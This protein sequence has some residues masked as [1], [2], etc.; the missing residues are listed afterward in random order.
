LISIYLVDLTL[1]VSMI[2]LN[3][4]ELIKIFW[5]E[6][7]KSTPSV[8]RIHQ[9]LES[10]GEVVMNDHIAFRT[11]NHPSINID[12]TEKVFLKCGYVQKDT[13]DFE[14]KKLV[15]RHYEHPDPMAPKVFISE[16][17]LEEFSQELRKKVLYCISKIPQGLLQTGM[18]IFSGRTW[19]TI[20]YE[21]YKALLEESEYA[22][23]LYV[24]GFCAN[25]F[26]V[27]V[28]K[29]QTFDSLEELNVFLKSNDFDL[30]QS[31]GEIKGGP[32]KLLA[33]SSTIADDRAVEFAEGLY[34]I[35]SCYYEFA[36][37]YP[38]LTGNLYQGFVA[39]S[40]DK[41]FESTNFLKPN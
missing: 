2:E 41:I 35:P 20:S 1:F 11:F 18:Y 29:L 38:D 24:Y 6:Y 27:D 21:T 16:L 14:K 10:R 25:H 4:K 28:N 19:G 26:T 39:Q 36:F 34:S 15:A 3:Y 7:Q 9:L 30:N 12:Q 5:G 40:A 37:R 13:Y 17:K 31:G 33:Q 22:A 8:G 32:D 23:W